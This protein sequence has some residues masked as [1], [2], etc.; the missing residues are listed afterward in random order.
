MNQPETQ[1]PSAA[2]RNTSAAELYADVLLP[3]A[4]NSVLTYMLPEHLAPRAQKGYRVVVPLGPRKYHTGIVVRTHYDRPKGDFLLK[5]VTEAPDEQ[6]VVTEAQLDLWRW[7]TRYYLCTPGEVMRA[8]LPA[9]LRSESETIVCLSNDNDNETPLKPRERR[10]AEVLRGARPT[11]M[12]KL[13]QETGLKDLFPTLRNMLEKGWLQV[14]ET[15]A[16]MPRRTETH[17]RLLPPWDTD[18]QRQHE[19]LDSLR[20]SQ[21]QLQIVLHLLDPETGGSCSKKEL[22]AHTGES[23][24]ALKA[25]R[26]KGVVETFAVEV[27]PTPAAFGTETAPPPPLSEA[28]QRAAEE[29]IAAWKTKN[30][31]LLHG[32]TSSGKTEVYIHLIERELAAGRQV[33][34]LLPEIALTTQITTR[35]R[36]V[37][38]DRMGVYHSKFPDAAR[39]AL[40]RRQNSTEACP[41]ILGVRS[42]LFLPFTRLGLIIVDEE[43]ETTYK[44]Q[45]TAPRYH[46][47][48]TA[49]MLARK[50]GARVLLGTATPAMETYYNATKGGKYGLV[51]LTNRFG[52]AQLPEIA[53]ENVAELRRKK[54]MN[55]PF[56]PRLIEEMDTALQQ[57]EQ[58]IL[59]LNRRG[60]APVL[61]C[62]TC[63]WT[64]KCTACD[65]A[66]TFHQGMKKLVCH[67]CGATYD[68][69]RQCPNCEDTEL[70]DRG[71]GTEKIEAAVKELFP[72]ARTA[73]MDLDTTRSRT[74]YERIIQDFQQGNS[75]ILI[76]TQMV[77]K[78]LDFDRVRVV[79]IVTADQMLNR[80][81]FRAYER[82]FQMMAQVAGRAGRRGKKGI[83]VLQTRQ[84]GLPVVRQVVSNDYNALFDDQMEE[85]EYFLYPPFC[86]LIDITVQHR[87]RIACARAAQF[88]A[89][90]L[91]PHFDTRLLGPEEPPVARVRTL[92][93]QKM[94]VKATPDL[95]PEGVRRT[96]RAA[97]DLLLAAPEGRGCGVVFDADPA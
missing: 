53:V 82:A 19:L 48:D 2:P 90:L 79:G 41:L 50:C 66:L 40:W 94:M 44:Q 87:D 74:A 5:P 51:T 58:I 10:I 61:E 23:T 35:L 71:Y 47:R 56:T 64:P 68:L 9:G 70:R 78:G 91:R 73:R 28:Q 83:V 65:V 49:M 42:A 72:K 27:K 96:L 39:M 36:R 24:S 34:Y 92:F 31:C 7:M 69:P 21:R 38:G 1:S 17:V 84:P 89:G 12:A 86:R 8:A 85:R 13:E 43:H 33:L 20:R 14:Y 3:L 16:E 75:D 80:P 77:T 37:F 45:D 76:G 25:L 60:F 54:L 15:L 18:E 32:V 88:L 4:F 57:G 55:T 11:K 30:T 67:Y 52:D 93:L 6:P 59:F 46:A 97:H 81:D 26:D 29:I 95:P 63:G 62:R 22:P